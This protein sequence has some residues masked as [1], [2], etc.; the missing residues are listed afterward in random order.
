MKIQTIRRGTSALLALFVATSTMG[1]FSGL[2]SSDREPPTCP[3]RYSALPSNIVLS[4]GIEADIHAM[5]GYTPTTASNAAEIYSIDH[6]TG[7]R[8]PLF[9]VDLTTWNES[10]GKLEVLG[11]HC[12]RYTNG[13]TIQVDPSS[14]DHRVEQ[15]ADGDL[16]IS[17]ESFSLTPRGSGNIDHSAGF[18]DELKNTGSTALTVKVACYHTTTDRIFHLVVVRDKSRPGWSW[19][20]DLQTGGDLFVEWV[21]HY[22]LQRASARYDDIE[23]TADEWPLVV[24]LKDDYAALNPRPAGTNFLVLGEDGVTLHK[25]VGSPSVV[26]LKPDVHIDVV[27]GP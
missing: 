26:A 22:R 8:D 2:F 17:N 6:Q 21:W 27:Q 11:A 13:Y 3:P 1:C 5:N 20:I 14:L 25:I 23:V 7:G 24:L 16:C 15:T 19:D 4:N 18:S 12:L 10:A 9:R